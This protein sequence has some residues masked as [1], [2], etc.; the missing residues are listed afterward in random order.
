MTG[1]ELRESGADAAS[2][3]SALVELTS[4]LAQAETVGQLCERALGVVERA[5][6]VE[7]ASVLLFDDDGVMRFRAWSGLSDAYRAAT[8]GHSPWAPDTVD[9]QPIVVPNV[10]RDSELEALREV[11]LEE[12]IRALAFVPI[13]FEH[14][15]LGK[16]ML[17]FPEPRSLG[18]GEL[19]IARIVA[20]QIAVAVKRHRDERD[21]RFSRDQLRAIFSGV[22]DAITVQTATGEL[23]YANDAAARFLGA[24]DPEELLRT[25]VSEIMSRFEVF[26]EDGSPLQREQLPARQIFAGA[27]AAERVVC[28]RVL[29][30]GDERWSLVRATPVMDADG[31][32]RLAVNVVQDIT[33]QRRRD[34]WQQLLADTSALLA[35]SLVSDDTLRRIA[36]LAV[37]GLADWCAVHVPKREE[38]EDGIKTPRVA[39]VAH[40]DPERV[41]MALDLVQQ[42]P[43]EPEQQRGAAWALHTGTSQL[44]ENLTDEML[45]QYARSEEHLRLLRALELRSAMIVPLIARG[46][47]LATISFATSGGRRAFRSEDLGD[48]EE[49]ARRAALAFDNA[50]LHEA[51]RDARRDA[52]LSAALA[53]RLQ[54]VTASLS[55]AITSQQVGEVIAGQGVLAVGA[56]AGLVLVSSED[57]TEL[58]LLAQVGYPE[59]LIDRHARTPVSRP[60]PTTEALATGNLVAVESGEQLVERWPHYREAQRITGDEATVAAP[61]PV[62]GRRGGVLYVAFRAP[63]TFEEWELD[64]VRTLARQCGQ[65]L[66][67]AMLYEQEHEVAVALQRSL[68]PRRL[69]ARDALQLAALY[70]PGSQGLN[71]GGDWY[72]AVDLGDGRIAIAVGDVVGHGLEAATV[73][74]ELRYAM[75]PYLVDGLAPDE[76]LTR[77]NALAL[78]AGDL[79]QTGRA[80]ATV[81]VAVVDVEGR[82]LTY[83][84]AGHPPPLLVMADGEIAFLEVRPG[85]PVGALEDPSYFL[86]EASLEPGA[87]LVLYTDGLVERRNRSLQAGFDEL[88]RVVAA[89]GRAVPLDDLCE[90]VL[91]EMVPEGEFADDLALLV[92]RLLDTP[93]LRRHVPARPEELAPLRR[94][95]RTWLRESGAGDDLVYDV[96]LA[97]SEACANAIEHP[98]GRRDRFIDLEA[99][100][101]DA[102]IRLRVRDTGTWREPEPATRRGR[103]LVLI[104]SLMDDIVIERSQEG[105]EVRMTRKL[106][107]EPAAR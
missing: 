77:L 60:G 89:Q 49:F 66:E 57:G 7:R 96:T 100:V 38:L 23:V 73:M 68:L 16:Y 8:D 4:A 43:P 5:L 2:G 52:E 53:R 41:R 6:G 90:A 15:L 47:T 54:S 48:A 78:H 25:P 31:K 71:V 40:R 59:N 10:E 36:E 101:V 94:A 24:S 74:G 46:R 65:A 97:A 51:E 30:T 50:L 35:E 9:A 55:G 63:R 84:S 29:A 95:L 99:R 64:V 85:P 75:R 45:A 58:E 14:Q 62:G 86:A 67:R 72:D 106:G 80:F 39:A 105:T 81:F 92:L 26:N 3:M 98:V 83:A 93:T 82:S 18:P 76:T 91:S 19:Q 11:I 20:D 44:M 37:P 13:S 79:S 61:L 88:A 69:P 56:Q 17:Y 102:Q 22:A 27:A 87:T 33:A 32:A 21:L 34:E 107:R 70:R 1:G 103:G 42:Y 12:G 104:E 28:Y